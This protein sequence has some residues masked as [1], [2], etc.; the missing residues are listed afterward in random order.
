MVKK[1]WK[2]R[3]KSVVLVDEE[4]IPGLIE[5]Q[6]MQRQDKKE[7]V[8]SKDELKEIFVKISAKKKKKKGDDD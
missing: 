4:E 3:G 5:K 6:L 8:M 7:K 2:P 1:L